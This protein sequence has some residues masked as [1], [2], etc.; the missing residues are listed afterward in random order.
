[1]KTIERTA[2]LLCGAL[3][4]AAA[5][6]GPAEDAVV[7]LQHGWEE[8]KYAAPAPEQEKR[9][10][11]LAAQADEALARYPDRA[12]VLIWHGIVKASYAGAKGGLGALSLAKGARQDFEQALRIDP[13]ALAGSAYTSLGS[14]YYQVPGWPIGFGNDKKA[15]ENLKQGLALNPDGIDPNFF[16]GDY[17][18]RNGKLDDAERYLRKAL[19][20]PP[21]PDRQMAD[22]GR[23]KEINALLA[24]I[25]EQRR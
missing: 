4:A 10:E 18:Y 22:E 6:A 14:L 1:M 11:R 21:R 8:V 20:A 3:L 7:R 2:V 15:E 24:K 16:Y 12:D 9:F 17:L 19:Q 5:H 13:K 23:R 25:A